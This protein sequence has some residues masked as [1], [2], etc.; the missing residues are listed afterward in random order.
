MLADMIIKKLKIFV[1]V[2]VLPALLLIA[3]GYLQKS[4]K[5]K[6]NKELIK[7]DNSRDNTK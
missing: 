3:A 6:T 7:P 2:I 5:A 4:S 1:L